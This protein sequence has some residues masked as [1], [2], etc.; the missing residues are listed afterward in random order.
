M[1]CR[2]KLAIYNSN[3]LNNVRHYE[4]RSRPETA[5]S[6]MKHESHELHIS[7]ERYLARGRGLQFVNLVSN[8]ENISDKFNM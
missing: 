3:K 4:T 8:H 5:S 7:D 6:V 2:A 1:K